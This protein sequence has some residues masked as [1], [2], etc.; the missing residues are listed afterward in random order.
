MTDERRF[1]DGFYIGGATADWQFE[2]GF[3][4][5][6]RGLLVIDYCTDGDPEHPRQVTWVDADGNRGKSHWEEALPEGVI[7]TMFD[8]EYY[9]S[10]VAVDFYHHWREDIADMAEMGFTTFRFGTCWSR[11]FPTGLEEEPNQ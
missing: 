3:G 7:L 5:G 6:G 1:P 8:D 2:G 9:P 10:H 4:E 11:I